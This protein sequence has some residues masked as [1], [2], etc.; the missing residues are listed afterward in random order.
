MIN[1]IKQLLIHHRVSREKQTISAMVN[2]YC[3]EKHQ[4]NE[5]CDDCKKLLNYAHQRLDVCVFK[6]NKPACNHCEVHCYS[7]KMKEKV[8]AVMIFSG[9]RMLFKHPVL[10]FWH[11][12][13]TFRQAPVLKRKIQDQ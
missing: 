11:M 3:K 6:N 12:M 4:Q 9:P 1:K 5:L 2:I 8:K 13:D 7:N 10:S